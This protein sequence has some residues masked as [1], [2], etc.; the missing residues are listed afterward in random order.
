[1]KHWKIYAG[2]EAMFAHRFVSFRFLRFLVEDALR[3]GTNVIYP[4]PP[5]TSES[6]TAQQS[7]ADEDR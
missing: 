4:T 6:Q 1:M 7:A 5:G 3:V 2:K